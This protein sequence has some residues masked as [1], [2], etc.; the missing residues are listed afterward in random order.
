MLLIFKTH[1]AC[2]LWNHGTW[3]ASDNHTFYER[4][5]VFLLILIAYV[6][7]TLISPGIC[8][9]FGIVFFVTLG[10]C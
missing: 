9:Q 7:L 5:R 6:N 8:Y 4:K 2:N 1:F 3:M 10:L